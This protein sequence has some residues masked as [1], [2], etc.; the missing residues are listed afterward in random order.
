MP[1]GL[2]NQDYSVDCGLASPA[3]WHVI[4][5]A[6]RDGTFA[7]DATL[8]PARETM[9]VKASESPRGSPRESMA[10][11]DSISASWQDSAAA[12]VPFSTHAGEYALKF[13][14]RALAAWISCPRFFRPTG[15]NESRRQNAAFFNASALRIELWHQPSKPQPICSYVRFSTAIAHPIV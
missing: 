4:N 11:P 2:E 12:A 10:A 6:F 13:L 14:M 8:L 7:H 5:F 9:Y 15:V 1:K 3:V